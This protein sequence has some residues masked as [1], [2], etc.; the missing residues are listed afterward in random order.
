MKSIN[1]IKITDVNLMSETTLRR[2]Y[3]AGELERFSL[4]GLGFCLFVWV[5][6]WFFFS[7]FEYLGE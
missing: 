2:L 4:G 5:L 1:A 3:I 6:F 7:S